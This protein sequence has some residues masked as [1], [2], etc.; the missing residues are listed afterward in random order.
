MGKTG[1]G[2]S[3][4]GN[5]VLGTESFKTSAGPRSVTTA[6]RCGESCR[7]GYRLVVVDTPGFYDTHRGNDFIVRELV[8]IFA[9]LSPGFNA[10]LF[11]INT[12]RYTEESIKTKDLFFKTF[13]PGVAQFT[14]IVLTGM[15]QIFR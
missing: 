14:V 1:S 10:L 8:K 9:F 3:A 12:D 5:A 7:L 13:G 4:T 15:G 11:V 2:K 6:T